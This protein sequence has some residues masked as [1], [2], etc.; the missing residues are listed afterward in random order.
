MKQLFP[1]LL[2]MLCFACS[3]TVAPVELVGAYT[4]R[5]YSKP[6]EFYQDLNRI[7]R[8]VHLSLQLEVDSSFVFET[9]T[10]TYMGEWELDEGVVQL[11]VDRAE[12]KEH[13]LNSRLCTAPP[14]GKGKIF[15]FELSG[16]KLK[17]I[18]PQA[19]GSTVL[20]SLKRN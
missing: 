16:E 2:V 10:T 8:V 19:D 15:E 4:T 6:I 5:K 3:R 13:F 20:Y 1:F 18:H 9:C 7:R 14:S 12:Y 17:A 11:H